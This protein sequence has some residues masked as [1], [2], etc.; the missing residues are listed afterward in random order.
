MDYKGNFNSKIVSNI[1]YDLMNRIHKVINNSSNDTKVANLEKLIKPK[2]TILTEHSDTLN[3]KLVDLD[4]VYTEQEKVIQSKIKKFIIDYESYA[5]DLNYLEMKERNL[6]TDRKELEQRYKT[7]ISDLNLYYEQNKK[8][9]EGI[10]RF[11]KIKEDLINE[12][13]KSENILNK[14][15][16]IR[17]KMVDPS[18]LIQRGVSMKD[19]F[20]EESFLTLKPN[21][22]INNKDTNEKHPNLNHLYY[23]VYNFY[24]SD[25]EERYTDDELLHYKPDNDNYFKSLKTKVK[26]SKRS[27]INRYK[28]DKSKYNKFL[29]HSKNINDKKSKSSDKDIQKSDKANLV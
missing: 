2:V 12:K 11:E 14:N 10:S 13:I 1:Q 25:Y 19:L 28:N 7:Y 21:N 15:A 16:Y 27:Y 4:D 23:D 5:K 17:K 26:M 29:K 20:K 6:M 22:K 24:D 18:L 3:K 9:L 8:M